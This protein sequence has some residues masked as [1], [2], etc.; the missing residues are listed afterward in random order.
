MMISVY[1]RRQNGD[2]KGNQKLEIAS[3]VQLVREQE[4]AIWVL[5]FNNLSIAHNIFGKA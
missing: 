3:H 2:A 1:V 4:P 5:K